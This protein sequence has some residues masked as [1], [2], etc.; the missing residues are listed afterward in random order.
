MDLYRKVI[1]LG[2]VI[3]RKG[4]RVGN[5]KGNKKYIVDLPFLIIILS[6]FLWHEE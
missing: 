1:E 5:V 3:F 2:M 4:N 6:L